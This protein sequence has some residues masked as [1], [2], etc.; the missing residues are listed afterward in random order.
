MPHGSRHQKRSRL[1][2]LC[3][4][5]FTGFTRQLHAFANQRFRLR[6]I[7]TSRGEAR[8]R[9][10]IAGSD[11]ALRPRPVVIKMHFADKLRVFYQHFG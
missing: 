3:Q 9:R 8:R 10:L 5:R 1:R 4:I 2:V 11:R 7:Q 6:F